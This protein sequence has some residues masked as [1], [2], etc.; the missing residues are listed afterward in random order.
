M[1][2]VTFNMHRGSTDQTNQVA[3]KQSL[4]EIGKTLMV[5]PPPD[6]FKLIP[7]SAK[8]GASQQPPSVQNRL[9]EALG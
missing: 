2:Q 3:V 5:I 6:A 9:K 8:H 4:V 7:Q 1:P